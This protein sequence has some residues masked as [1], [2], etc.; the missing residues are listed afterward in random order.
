M[1]DCKVSERYSQSVLLSDH[2]GI[3]KLRTE[4]KS[5]G[6]GGLLVVVNMS[7]RICPHQ[8]VVSFAGMRNRGLLIIILLASSFILLSLVLPT[9]NFYQFYFHDPVLSAKSQLEIPNTITTYSHIADSNLE[10]DFFHLTNEKWNDFRLMNYLL[11]LTKMRTLAEID[12]LHPSLK[13]YRNDFDTRWQLFQQTASVDMRLLRR[14]GG[15]QVN[16]L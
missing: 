9:W 12:P 7:A 4:K 14:V 6:V 3:K 5:E 11:F 16:S 10:S 15:K 8:A 1:F 2:Y 13:Y